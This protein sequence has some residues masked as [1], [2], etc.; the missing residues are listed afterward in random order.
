MTE[1]KDFWMGIGITGTIC[2][3]IIIGDKKDLPIL[4]VFLFVVIVLT[5]M[6][7]LDQRFKKN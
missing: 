5:I 6:L 4:S 2:L 7:Y 3:A 1:K